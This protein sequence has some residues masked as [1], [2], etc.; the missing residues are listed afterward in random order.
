VDTLI[1]NRELMDWA[2]EARDEEVEF[3]ELEMPAATGRL[4]KDFTG[5]ISSRT[6]AA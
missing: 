4:A 2:V 1:V 3:P 6:E 5:Q